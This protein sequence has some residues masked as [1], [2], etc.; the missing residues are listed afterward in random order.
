M[1]HSFLIHSFADGHL[2]CFRHLAIVSCAV[3]NI[4]VHRFFWIGVSGF[5][6]YNPSSGVAGSK[7]SSIFSFLRNFHTVSIV[8]AQVC[9]PTNSALSSLFSTSSPT[10]VVCCFV[11][12]GH[13][14]WCGVVS[15]CGFNLHLSSS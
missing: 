3:V 10:L 2:G 8:V 7:G 1:Y 12:D 14:D 13:S 9:N 6:G 5:L 15:H 11:Y 4:G